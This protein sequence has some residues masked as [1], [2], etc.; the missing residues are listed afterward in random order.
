LNP[1]LEDILKYDYKLLEFVWEKRSCGCPI[2]GA[3]QG[4]IGW[5]PEWPPLVKGV[6][7]HGRGV[8]TASSLRFLSTQTILG[9]YDS[10]SS[11]I[12]SRL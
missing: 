6:P 3:V 4:Q 1:F 11:G 10:V 7:A 12:N 2:P 9:F 8:A 5:S